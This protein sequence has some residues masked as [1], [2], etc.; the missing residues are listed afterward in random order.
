MKIQKY[1]QQ[2]NIIMKQY[3]HKLTGAIF[4]K[5]ING[6]SYYS[7][8][9]QGYYI[10]SELLENSCD[11][12]EVVEKDW[13]VLSVNH[14]FHGIL[15]IIGSSDELNL[16]EGIHSIKRLSDGEVF[17]AGDKIRFIDESLEETYPCRVIKSFKEKNNTLIAVCDDNGVEI[18]LKNLKHVRTPILV[19]QDGVELFEMT[20][21]YFVPQKNSKG[22]FSGTIIEFSVAR[23]KNTDTTSLRFSTKEKAKEYIDFYIPK[24]SLNDINKALKFDRPQDPF[25]FTHTFTFLERLRNGN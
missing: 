2:N 18:L 11:Y 22:T 24:Y 1:I 3:K 4:N 19:T 8:K 9:Y 12:E 13:E 7:D 6:N 17:K 14:K 16:H 20:D 5:A 15:R 23:C 21:T 10:P 25:G